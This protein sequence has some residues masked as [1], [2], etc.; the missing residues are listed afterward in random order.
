MNNG[1]RSERRPG[2]LQSFRALK[3]RNFRWY[4][5]SGLG[6]TGAQ[7]IKQ[8]ALAW[9]VLDLTGSVG[10]LGLVVFMQ[11]LPMSIMALFGGVLADRYDHRKLL[12]GNQVLSMVNILLVALLT[13]T[14]NIDLWHIYASSIVLGVTSSLTMPARNAM[15]RDLVDKQDLMNAVALNTMQQQSSRILWPSVA[16]VMIG[17]V[18]VGPTLLISAACFVIGIW[19]LLMMRGLPKGPAP[20]SRTSPLRE[21]KEGLTYTWSNATTGMTM[22]IAL[23]IGMFGLAFNQLGPGFARQEMH[24]GPVQTGMFLMASGI[25]S[26]VG[27]TALVVIDVKNKT[28]V[29]VACCIGFAASLIALSVN[30]WS[31]LSFG[32]MTAFGLSNSALAVTAQTIFQISASPQYLGRVISLWAVAGGLASTTALPLGV[33]GDIFGLRWALGGAAV[34]LLAITVW[35]GIVR[36]PS[37]AIAAAVRNESDEEANAVRSPSQAP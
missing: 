3:H 8:L 25:G 5:L 9:L 13:V 36:Y 33:L 6:M 14:G 19:G 1:N 20:I 7:G 18:D 30:P 31:Y 4:W 32:I 2:W 17:V 22:T 12:I 10:Q 11:G 21:M 24:F 35:V 15:I 37:K 29:Y 23:A 16:G 34:I 27:S 26:V 28:R